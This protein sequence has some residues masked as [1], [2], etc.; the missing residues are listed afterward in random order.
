MA[1]N[2][3]KRD[4]YAH[5]VQEAFVIEASS[6]EEAALRVYLTIYRQDGGTY[7]FRVRSPD[8]TVHRVD[9]R[10]LAEAGIINI[11]CD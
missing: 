3:S 6:A 1:A 10:Q 11:D 7:V 8:G 5:I 9:L 2:A 4:G